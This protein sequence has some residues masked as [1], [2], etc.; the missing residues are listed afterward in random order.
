MSYQSVKDAVNNN[1][2]P[3]L[4]KTKGKVNENSERLILKSFA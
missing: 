1:R 2:D 4:R 3:N